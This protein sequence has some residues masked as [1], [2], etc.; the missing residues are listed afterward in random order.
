MTSASSLYST[1]G[2]NG[3]QNILISKYKWKLQLDF[4]LLLCYPIHKCIG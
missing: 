1:L 3:L 2:K 4:K